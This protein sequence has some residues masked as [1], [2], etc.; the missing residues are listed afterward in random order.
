MFPRERMT[1][2]QAKAKC[3][4]DPKCFGF[5]YIESWATRN[6]FSFGD[7][8]QVLQGYL[9]WKSCLIVRAN[10]TMTTTMTALTWNAAQGYIEGG[11]VPTHKM[12]I[13]Q[14]KT[15]C[16]ED[17]KCFGF[18]YVESWATRNWFN[19][20][21]QFNVLQGILPWKSYLNEQSNPTMTLTPQRNTTSVIEMQTRIVAASLS[22]AWHRLDKVNAGFCEGSA[23]D[24]TFLK[25]TSFAEAPLGGD[26]ERRCLQYC[27]GY[28]FCSFNYYSPRKHRKFCCGR[29]H[30][31]SSTQHGPGVGNYRI[32]TSKYSRVILE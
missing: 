11:S 14:A 15:K 2:D 26:D 18:S 8:P 25:R 5:S 6:L 9:P 19:F 29:S 27:D 24:C 17:P 1:T 30:T 22:R 13:D 16:E 20:G 7:Q 12:T 10:Q 28:A 3:E 4:E 23:W 31:C 32:Y 21:Y